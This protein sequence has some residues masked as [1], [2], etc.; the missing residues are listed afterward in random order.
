MRRSPCQRRSILP[1]QAGS[2]LP[3]IWQLQDSIEIGRPPAILTPALIF[4]Q[5][6]SL[7]EI[8]QC[9]ANCR[10]GEFQL[11]RYGFD[12]RPADAI[13][14]GAVF[15]IHIYRSRP[16]RQ[17]REIN[18]IKISHSNHHADRC[19]VCTNRDERVQTNG[20]LSYKIRQRRSKLQR[21]GR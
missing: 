2:M 19:T 4:R 13:L 5:E 20:R 1:P 6:P 17:V 14:I 9:T 15:E 10:T 21:T 16:V 11:P 12:G 3:R 7:A 18:R 8:V